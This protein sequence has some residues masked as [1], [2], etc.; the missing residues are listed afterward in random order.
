[1]AWV[2]FKSITTVFEKSRTIQILDCETT[3]S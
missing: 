1:M 2:E 3:V